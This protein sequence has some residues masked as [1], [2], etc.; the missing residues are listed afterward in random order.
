MK[1]EGNQIYLSPITYEDTKDIVRWRNKPSVREHFIYREL[2]TSEIHEKWMKNEVE[3]GKVVQFIIRDRGTEQKIGSVYLRDIDKNNRK[4]EFGIFIGE[5]DYLN[6]G[7]GREAAELITEYAFIKMNIHKI[8]L[9]LL[10]HNLRALHSYQ[11]AGFVQEG[12]SK[13]DVWI[14]GKPHDVIFMS[15]FAPDQ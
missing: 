1:I 10:A 5:E 15:K 13:D 6:K 11:K 14:D 4:C 7:Y 3:T 2:F 9:R 12:I 8:Y